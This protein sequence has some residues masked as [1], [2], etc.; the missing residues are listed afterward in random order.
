MEY[1]VNINKV[2]VKCS[3]LSA[4]CVFSVPA[5]FVCFGFPHIVAKYVALQL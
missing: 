5:Y 2:F 3:L 4:T 1:M